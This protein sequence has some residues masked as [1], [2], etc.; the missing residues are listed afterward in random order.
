MSYQSPAQ[1]RSACLGQIQITQT[2][3]HMVTSPASLQPPNRTSSLSEEPLD[4]RMYA[5]I[6]RCLASRHHQPIAVG[7]D[8]EAK[9]F[10]FFFLS[11]MAIGLSFFGF[12]R[13]RLQGSRLTV[14]IWKCHKKSNQ[15]NRI[16]TNSYHD[17]IKKHV[18]L[19]Q[20]AVSEQVTSPFS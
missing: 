4:I 16:H 2:L 1:I 18:H 15:N 13:L 7:K 12:L 10:F 19:Q 8:V 11:S 17:P 5:M 9:P 3:N 6:K 14:H 20:Q